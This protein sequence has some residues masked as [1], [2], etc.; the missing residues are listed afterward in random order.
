MSLAAIKE[1]LGR[2][3]F[4]V[5][6]LDLEGRL[7]DSCYSLLDFRA[8]VGKPLLSQF[9]IFFGL[10]DE[11]AGMSPSDPPLLMPVITFHFQDRD[12]PLSFEFHRRESDILWVIHDNQRFMPRLQAMQQQRNDSMIL[13]E[14]IQQQDRELRVLNERLANA[15]RE[16]DQFAYVVSHDLKAPL[17]AVRNLSEWIAEALESGEVAELPQQL[18]LLRE[19]ASKM[20]GLIEGILRYS[21]AGRVSG[22]V[23]K[24]S[25][26]EAIA[27]AWEAAAAGEHAVLEVPAALPELRSHRVW[28]VEVFRELM[29]NSVAHA[30][31]AALQVTVRCE[32]REKD[33]VFEFEDNGQGIPEASWE[34]VFEVF[35]TLGQDT[36]GEQSGVGLPIVRKILR[37]AGGEIRLEAGEA[38][39]ARFV[40]AWPKG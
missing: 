12:H 29:E 34:K 27:E 8:F 6:L 16:L 7:L 19:R 1:K 37:A 38:G 21:R 25:V 22:T 11:I 28:L 23:R 9:D 26:A 36:G 14:R 20:D 39:G 35:E 2:S 3:I 40:F 4:Q 33:W 31:A 13:L 17:R 24:V 18:Q 30:G 15:V 5:V 10:V 32:E